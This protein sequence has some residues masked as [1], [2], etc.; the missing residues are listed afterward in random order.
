MKVLYQFVILTMVVSFISCTK[1]DVGLPEENDTEDPTSPPPPFNV[2]KE[3]LLQ[4]VNNVRRTGC[5]CGA[6][7]MPPVTAV[8][9]NDLLATAAYNHSLDMKQKNY[10]SHTAPDGSSPGDRVTRAGYKWR[11]YGENIAKGYANE[12]DVMDGWLNSEGHCK[13]IMNASFK[14]MGVARVDAYWTQVFGSR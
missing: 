13:N 2:N 6:T 5:N 1:T 10:F 12:K 14:E 7:V 8:T 11:S 3:T 4:L 9:W